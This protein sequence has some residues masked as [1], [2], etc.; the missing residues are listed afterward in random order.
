M[1][2]ETK[3]SVC[4]QQKNGEFSLT[5]KLMRLFIIALCLTFPVIFTFSTAWL[6]RAEPKYTDPPR[7]IVVPDDF[8]KIQDAIDNATP[9]DTVYVRGGLYRERLLIAK[10]IFLVGENNSTAIVEGPQGEDAMTVK[11]DNVTVSG[12]TVKN[13][14]SSTLFCGI[15][16]LNSHNTTISDNVITGNFEGVA[17][18]S[19][20]GNLIQYN[21]ITGNHYG[22]F[23]SNFTTNNVIFHNLVSES[24]WNGIEL[25]WGGE[26]TV[27]A[28]TIINNTAYGLEIPVYAPSLN[29]VIFHNNFVNNVHTVIEGAQAVFQ[30]YGPPSNSWDSKGEGNY[31]SDYVGKDEDHDGIGDAPHVTMYGT[32]DNYPLMGNFSDIM[33]SGFYLTMVSDS[34]IIGSDLSLSDKRATLS[35]SIFQK[36]NSTGFCRISIP[37]TLMTGPYEVR[38][39]GEVMTYPQVR[40]LPSSDEIY[41]CVYVDFPVG[42]HTVEIVGTTVLSEFSLPMILLFFGIAVSL[43]YML[44]RK[45]Y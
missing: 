22:I 29:N 14:E 36:E 3:I 7:R 24:Y 45:R 41:K 34:S 4:H 21:L 8:A 16:L 40:E 12:F 26:N 27:C 10:S 23:T 1:E 35:L 20:S 28:N 30:A 31:W 13:R 5:V 19:G 33:T 11:A 37:K 15:K 25:D 43:A 39:D 17:V 42:K 18:V 6:N 44:H 2:V 38:L 9:G 32:A